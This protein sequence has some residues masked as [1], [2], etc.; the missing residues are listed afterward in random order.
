MFG[1]FAIWRFVFP[2]HNGFQYKWYE[3]GGK[4]KSEKSICKT[5]AWLKFKFQFQLS[6]QIFDG[7]KMPTNRMKKRIR[8]ESRG[9][10]DR[11]KENRKKYLE[12]E[13]KRQKD[14]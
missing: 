14:Q 12:Q 8:V 7:A 2:F 4:K 13:T 11:D 3:K 6:K 5:A 9:N 10:G 1:H